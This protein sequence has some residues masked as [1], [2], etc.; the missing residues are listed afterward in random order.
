[1][2]GADKPERCAAARTLFSLTTAGAGTARR[3]K[4]RLI[5]ESPD[6]FPKS[7]PDWA[8]AA[9]KAITVPGAKREDDELAHVRRAILSGCSYVRP[10]TRN[11]C[12]CAGHSAATRAA[13][14]DP[15]R[16]FEATIG[17]CTAER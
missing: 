1:M 4:G 9:K 10:N 15:S 17:H 3:A 11:T 13:D 8:M 7:S 2:A 5:D 14:K 6:R 16:C 12:G